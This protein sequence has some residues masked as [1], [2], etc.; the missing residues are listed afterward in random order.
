M[1][2]DELL[3]QPEADYM[4]D[5]QQEFFRALLRRQRQALQEHIATALA[6]LRDYPSDS[7][8]AD[9]G[10]TEEQRQAHLRLLE[11]ERKLLDKIDQALLRL[12]QGD[13]GWCQAT[14]EPIGLSRLLVRPTATLSIDAK[15][16]Q[17]R[18]EKHLRPH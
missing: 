18:L 15:Q 16:R 13:Y 4:N 6:D 8:P 12:A 11:R 5:R 3:A 1:T 9:A 7:D 2:P 10:S 14:G 17:E